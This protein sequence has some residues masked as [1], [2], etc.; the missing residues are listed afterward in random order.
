MALNDS[1]TDVREGEALDA[2]RV[3]AYLRA[4]LPGLQGTPSVRQF[5]GGASNLTYLLQYPGRQLVLRRPPFGHKAR[6]AHDMGREFRILSALRNAYPYCPDALLHCT[7]AGVIGAEFYVMERIE[8]VILRTDLPAELGL[9]AANTQALC[10]NF[11]ARL[12]ELHRVDYRACGL[13][14][15]GRPEGY[16]QRQVSGWSERYQ[17]ALTPDAPGWSAVMA[18]LADK[19][20]PESGRASLLHNDFRFDNVILDPA[21]PL[22]IVGV[23]D[24]ELAALGDPLM[25]L[26]NSLAYWIE[27][28]DPAPVQMMRRQPSHAPGMLTREQFVACYAEGAGIAVSNMDF[29]RVYGLFRLAGII[30]QIYFRFYHGQ[31]QDKR[32]AAFVHMNKLLEQMSLQVID[33]STL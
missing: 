19:L 9:D 5:P 2:E 30:Q 20:P 25:D 18:W 23:L 27:A 13:G 22:R 12:V 8:G 6:S 10:E 24:W 26:G 4:H 3:A 15:L 28:G 32:F 1:A 16:V 7:D 31:T 17:Q 21:A 33:K 14:D 29:Y 11:I